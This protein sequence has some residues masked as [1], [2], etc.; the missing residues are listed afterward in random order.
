M[1]SVLGVD[2]GRLSQEAGTLDGQLSPLSQVRDSVSAGVSVATNSCGSV[3]DDG[4]RGALRN[5]GDA[6]GYEVA[7]IGGDLGSLA[8]VMNGL[9]QAYAQLDASG[10]TAVNG[11]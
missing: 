3:S 6:W 8:Q 10:A 7:A 1:T 9:A 4:L 2:T 5:L 11:G